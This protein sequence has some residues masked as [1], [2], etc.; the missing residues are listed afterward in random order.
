MYDAFA[1][2]VLNGLG[3]LSTPFPPQWYRY[4]VVVLVDVVL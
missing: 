1:M 2:D 3:R 4:I